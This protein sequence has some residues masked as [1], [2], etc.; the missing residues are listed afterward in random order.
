MNNN[1]L[2]SVQHGP[3]D[4]WKVNHRGILQGYVDSGIPKDE[5]INYWL[6]IDE[7][8]WDGEDMDRVYAQPRDNNMVLGSRGQPCGDPIRHPTHYTVGGCEAIDVI[9]SKLTREEYIGYCKG[10][11][12][13]Y[14][15][16]ANYKGHHDTDMGKAE[17]YIGSM[18][19][20]IEDGEEEN[21]YKELPNPPF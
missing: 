15:M 4:T 6:N 20:V 13:K 12:L 10:N 19:E 21:F 3:G 14:L 18:M 7:G 9:K 5:V 1:S 2:W 11:V 16:R 17:Y 8:D